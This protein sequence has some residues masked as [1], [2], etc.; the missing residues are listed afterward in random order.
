[1]AIPAIAPYPMPAETPA[2][3]VAWEPDAGRAVLLIHDMQNYF[4]RAFTPGASPL[5]E[6]MAN[7]LALRELCGGLGVPVVYSAQPGGQSSEER[8]LL[9]DFWGDGIGPDPEE[10]AIVAELAPRP[11][12]VLLTKWRYSAY[13]R[14]GLAEL[15]TELGRDQLI[16]CGV[17]AHIGVLMTACEA[18]MRDVRPFVVADAVADFSLEHHEMAIRYAAQRCAVT[19]TTAR[20]GRALAGAVAGV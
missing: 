3:R 12:D 1:M 15:M 16:V 19:T 7:V 4:L 14:T 2:N 8:G 6:L 10:A 5:V 17:Y 11:G 20:I 9:L 18:F 13:Q